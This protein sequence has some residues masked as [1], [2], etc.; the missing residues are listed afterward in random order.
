MFRMLMI[1]MLVALLLGAGG[2]SLPQVPGHKEEQEQ[3]PQEQ[4]QKTERR[5]ESSVPGTVQVAPALAGQEENP[6]LSPEGQG[7]ITAGIQET[8][9]TAFETMRIKDL[10]K[11]D[12]VFY[13]LNEAGSVITM[14]ELQVKV[15]TLQPM[16]WRLESST[17]AGKDS[18]LV[19]VSYTL[20]DGTVYQAEPFSMIDVAG[21]WMIHY[22]SFA[23]SFNTMAGHLPGASEAEKRELD[24]TGLTAEKIF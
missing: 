17:P 22:N 8:L 23:A 9:T 11:V 20:P 16:E 19:E 2:C 10:S 7:E 18:R 13:G 24:R 1:M 3:T 6:A 4:A 5:Q 14:E 21:I 12:T 15:E